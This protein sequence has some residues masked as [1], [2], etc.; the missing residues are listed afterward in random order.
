MGMGRVLRKNNYPFSEVARHLI[1]PAGGALLSLLAGQFGKARYHWS[2][3]AGR[4][5]GW[6]LTSE[7]R[8]EAQRQRPAGSLI[9]KSENL[10]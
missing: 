7:A 9:S 4:A 3:F 1:R 8:R 5:G 10:Q 6:R 2:I